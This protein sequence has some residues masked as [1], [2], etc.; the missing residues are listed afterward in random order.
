LE[1][2]FGSGNDALQLVEEEGGAEDSGEE[3]EGPVEAMAAG[4]PTI[5]TQGSEAIEE[6]H[7]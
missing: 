5:P 4:A 6:T 2:G 3:G 7:F 1:E